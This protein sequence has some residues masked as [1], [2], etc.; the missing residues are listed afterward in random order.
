MS[1]DG[2]DAGSAAGRAADLASPRPWAAFATG[3][4]GCSVVAEGR[5][6]PRVAR[7]TSGPFE[8][9]QA[10]AALIVEAVNAYDRLRAIEDAARDVLTFLPGGPNGAMPSGP[11]VD[12][13]AALR[14]ALSHDS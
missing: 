7:L 12:A 9:C 11:F 2:I 3:S 10:D 5:R 6:L 14:E 1:V 8:T 4:E 13:A